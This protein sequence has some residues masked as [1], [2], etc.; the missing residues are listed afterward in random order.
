MLTDGQKMVESL[1]YVPLP[2]EIVAKELRVI[3]QMK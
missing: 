3:Q 1:N 2:K